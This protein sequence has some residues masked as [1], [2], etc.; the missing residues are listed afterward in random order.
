MTTHEVYIT[1][2]PRTQPLLARAQDSVGLVRAGARAMDQENLLTVSV[3]QKERL[4]FPRKGPTVAIGC[5]IITGRLRG[6]LRA[7]RT[8]I[9]GDSLVSSIG[10]NVSYAAMQ[11]EG[12]EG[13]V[14]VKA[15]TRLLAGKGNLRH[16]DGRLK[17]AGERARGQVRAHTRHVSITGRHFVRD[18]LTARTPL[19]AS[20]IFAA[21]SAYPAG[22][23]K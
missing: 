22:G 16:A 21:M 23:G 11:E 5:R 9:M 20:A 17:T 2:D 19:Y 8:T 1:V 10:S 3:I 12:F 4:N 13:D 18:G 6:S 7:G 15:H 14:Q